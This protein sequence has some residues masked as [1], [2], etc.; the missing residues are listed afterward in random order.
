MIRHIEGC[1]L[2]NKRNDTVKQNKKCNF[3]GAKFLMKSNRDCHIKNIHGDEQAAALL[4]QEENNNEGMVSS[5]G[6]A[7]NCEEDSNIFGNNVLPTFIAFPNEYSD[8]DIKSGEE[9]DEGPGNLKEDGKKSDNESQREG[10][11]EDWISFNR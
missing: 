1:H 5:Q 4:S 6:Y 7:N 8:E 3:C 10:N 11:L 2:E 9:R